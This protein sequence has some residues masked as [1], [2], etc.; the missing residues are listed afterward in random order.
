MLKRVARAVRGQLRT[1]LRVRR[2]RIRLAA[3]QRERSLRV[4][5]GCGDDRL[6]G[7]INI[8][9][10]PTA[11]VDVTMDLT[12]PQLAA[13]SVSLAFSNAFFE[14]LY[15]SARVPHLQGIREALAPDGACCYIGIPYFPNIARFY[16][17]RGPGTA[18]PVFDLHN[19]YRYTHGDPEGQEAWWLGQLHKSLFDEAEVATLLS[20]SG[21]A[22]HRIFCYGYPG[23]VNEVPVT[24]GFYATRELVADA[25]LRQRSLAL[26]GQFDGLRLRL[27]T[28]EWLP[29][30]GSG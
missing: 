22:A 1:G 4:H 10:R 8:D 20:S 7:F 16:L 27:A 18:G 21:F 25:D 24:M 6:P 14:H 19:V 26:L 28:L 11:A 12:L 17:E 15:R 29:H 23:D 9:V 30:P 3:L 2:N 13:G 5:L